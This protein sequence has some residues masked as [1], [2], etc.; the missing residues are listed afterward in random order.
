MKGLLTELELA[1][2]IARKYHK[3]QKRLDGSEFIKHPEAVVKMVTDENY[4]YSIQIVAWLHDILEDTNMTEDKLLEL[5]INPFV[6]QSI[7]AISKREDE[8]YL[9]YILRCSN[10][11]DAKAVK[12]ADLRHNISTL[13]KGSLKD[14]YQ[15]A[16]Y[17]LENI[18]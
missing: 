17:L 1:E 14:K 5:G 10:D 2:K 4:G 8:R 9:D 6:I 15:L 7:V 12:K 11:D 18:L 3:G 13:K 16:L